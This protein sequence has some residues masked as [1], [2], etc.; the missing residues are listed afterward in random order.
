MKKKHIELLNYL[1]DHN[2][3]TSKELAAALSISTRSVKNYVI[4]INLLSKEKAILSSKHGY[5][6]QKNAARELLSIKEE[7]L[8]QTSEQ[9]GFYIIKAIML[10]H[11]SHVDIFDLCD[12]LYVS[13]STIK[14]DIAKMNKTFANFHVH[15]T[16]EN[17]AV[18]IHGS[19]KDKRKL[20]SYVMY[21]ETEQQ[22]MDSS[23]IKDSFSNISI[24]AI[25]SIIHT[26]FQKYQYYI[27][28]FAFVNLLLHFTIIIDRMKEG[29]F[30]D[31]Q[32]EDF[33][34]ES[35][36]ERSLV[37]ELCE[38]LEQTFHIKFNK[39]EQFEIYMLFKTN[40]NFSMPSSKDS[41][42][43]LVGE[44]ILQLT[45]DIVD[46]VNESYLIDLNQ[47]SFVTPFSLHLKNLLLRAHHK[48]YTKNPMVDAIKASCPTVY[49]I[50]IFISLELMH[51]Y[52]VDINEDEVTFLAL[53]IGAEIERQ[54][55]NDSKLRCVLLCP[56]YMNITTS[57]YNGLLM[58]FGNQINIIQTVSYEDELAPLHYDLLITTIPLKQPI[59]REVCMIP[60]FKSETSFSNLQTTIENLKMNQKNYI[61]KKNFHDFFSKELFL[62]DPI[63][64]KRDDVIHALCQK[65]EDMEYVNHEFE[66]KVMIRELA[67]STGF[68]NI[69]IPHAMEMEAWK[70]CISVAVSK[71]GIL[72][73]SQIVHIVL[74]V[75]IN[76]VDKK[77]FHDLYEALVILFS[78][79]T[80]MEAAKECQ[81]FQDFEQLVYT[82]ISYQEHI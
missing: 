56:D 71:Q 21:E 44:D 62:Y 52:H 45:K 39:N 4:E 28:D 17:D 23:M 65:M 69:A 60:P 3:A 80:V 22:F 53:H 25:T 70:T 35:D 26:T 40:A 79:D 72:W 30:V 36:I 14:A 66:E 8:P 38:Q 64:A 11:S 18:K 31:T 73:G 63:P 29:N 78:N 58:D 67:A 27:N 48:T 77:I 6:I 5:T 2:S 33:I 82:S 59:H 41:L 75:A 54:K 7:E 10:G 42:K 34:I 13:Y 76:K 32:K 68:V 1:M 46:K 47:E 16:C 19:E 37:S 9:R 49:D 74:L 57:I 51:R 81:S 12:S 43:R 15:F 50:A 61:L 55:T 20:V 24:D